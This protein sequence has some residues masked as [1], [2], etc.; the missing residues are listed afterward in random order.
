MNISAIFIK[1]PVMTILVMFSFLIAGI[2]GYK[3]LPINELPNIDFP[4]IQVT[5]NFP[6]ADPETMASSVAL[7][8]EKQFATIAGVDSLNSVSSQ[9]LTLITIQ[10]SLDRNIDAAAEDVQAAIAAANNNLPNLPTPPSYTKLNPAEAPILYVALTSDTVPLSTVDDYAE[11]L[12]SEKLSMVS[13]VAQVQIYGPQK[14]AV[15]IQLDPVALV[16]RGIG[17][18]EIESLIAK[19]NFNLPT[20]SLINQNKT[21]TINVEGQLFNAKQYQ[22]LLLTYRNG[23]P[24]F[25]R[26]VAN[27]IDGVENDQVAAWY[28]NKRAI[29]LAVQRQPGSNTVEVAEALRDTL[30]KLRAEI[31]QGI[32]ME[33]L[34]DRSI[35]IIQSVEDVEFSLILALILVVIVIFFF[36]KNLSST[37]I[38][39]LALPISLVGTFALMYYLG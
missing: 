7:P 13:G 29:V 33:V 31:P 2:I 28:N 25:L 30:P 16:N 32:K 1:R 22:N 37:I 10:F 5:V 4:T 3:L 20:G 35:S 21:A 14:Y 26:D 15:R 24:V 27:V 9:G 36:L 19:N 38:P 6:G 39:S 17:I 34:Y 11:I 23:A 12:I 18:D 8:L